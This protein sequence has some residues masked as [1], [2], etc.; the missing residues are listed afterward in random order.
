VSNREESRITGVFSALG[1]NAKTTLLSI[2]PEATLDEIVGLVQ[3]AGSGE[4]ELLVPNNTEELRSLAGCEKLKRAAS[5]AGV[6]VTLF[7]A[8][9][10]IVGTARIAKLDVVPVGGAISAPPPGR[11]R[12][13]QAKPHATVTLPAAGPRSSNSETASPALPKRETAG[14]SKKD[15]GRRMK[16]Q[17]PSDPLQP[18]TFNHH[19]SHDG[20][21]EF[22]AG[23]AA[24]ERSQTDEKTRAGETLPTDEG[25][26]LFDAPGDL[27]VPRPRAA[28][29]QAW[30]AAFD[31]MATTMATEPAQPVRRVTRRTTGSNQP[32]PRATSRPDQPSRKRS[33]REYI[34]SIA[35]FLTQRERPRRERRASKSAAIAAPSAPRRQLRAD[36]G[37]GRVRGSRRLLFWPLALLTLLG[38]AGG[39]GLLLRAF[40]VWP[41]GAVVTLTPAAPPSEPQPFAGIQIPVQDTPVSDPS[42]LQVQGAIIGQPVSVLAQGEAISTTLAPIGRAAGTIDLRNTLSQPVVL[43]A[44][45]PIRAANGVT[46]TVDEA[47]TIPAAVASADG[48]TFG[49]GAASLTAT[50]PGAA[51][52]IPAGSITS[53]PGFEGTLRV[54]QGAFSGGADQEVKV[55]RIEDVNR[56]L[57]EALSQLYGAGAQ[58]LQAKV[59]EKSGFALAQSTITPTLESLKQL[60][61]VDYAVFPPIGGVAPDGTFKLELRTAFQGV[62]EPTAAPIAQQLERAVRNQLANTGRIDANAQVQIQNWNVNN[63]SI[64]VDAMVRPPAKA[65]PLQAAFLDQVRQ[66]I[67]G[68]PRDEAQR[69]LDSLVKD[70]KIARWTLPQAWTTVPARV[71][72]Q[73]ASR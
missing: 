40:N 27:G 36:K 73:Q 19:P 33:P 34:G 54:E 21:Q 50:V 28:A 61:G 29:R 43:R 71:S 58:A 55:V 46:F 23:L 44:G 42:S 11:P 47:A 26:V 57:P 60:R 10:Q 64:V 51:G 8:D 53:I 3:A 18:S 67:A 30:E 15:E 24:F 68:K 45:T 49:R 63:Q 35:P 39:G 70:G 7:T 37:A 5:A 69:Y 17:G 41:G 72:V 4:V 20:E 66:A 13:P 14:A 65:P 9:E 1:N 59:A 38:A 16:D 31:D 48:I 6:H 22:L 25:A 32:L 62:A 56:V 12:S 2:G 52:N